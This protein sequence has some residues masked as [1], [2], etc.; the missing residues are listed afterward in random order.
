MAFGVSKLSPR[1]STTCCRAPMKLRPSQDSTLEH[2]Q[3]LLL[4]FLQRDGFYGPLLPTMV[5]IDSSA[6]NGVQTGVEV[7][8]RVQHVVSVADALVGEVNPRPGCESASRRTEHT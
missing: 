7:V 6:D 1:A 3:R 2:P 4:P 5:A 8:E